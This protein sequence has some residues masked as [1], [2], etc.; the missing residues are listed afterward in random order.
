MD[1]H[2]IARK[3]DLAD[4]ESLIRKAGELRRLS[5]L[6]FNSSLI[7]IGEVCKAVICLEIAATRLGVLFDRS[8]AIKLAGMSEKAY[9]RSFNLLQNGLGFK[10]RLDI[11]ELAVQFGC[12]RLVA[13]VQKGLSLY[14]DRFV[15]SLPASRRVSADFSRPVFTA[16]AFYLCAKKNKLKVDKVKLIEL[17]GTSESEFSCVATSM[18]DLCFDVFGISSVKKDPRDAKGNRDLLDALPEK[19]KREDGGYL[20]DDCE[21]FPRSKR[22]KPTA[23]QTYNQWKSSVIASNNLTKTK[24]LGKRTR[25]TSIHFFKEIKETDVK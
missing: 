3:L 10:S 15:A 14:K 16:V 12:V 23:E 1:F 2:N 21:E 22:C 24:V 11:R 17:S 19:R 20:S 18:K 4:S 7:G 13:S 8:S 6:H 9:T 25:Q 5:D